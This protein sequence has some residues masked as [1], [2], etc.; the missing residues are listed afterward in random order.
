MLS[1]EAIEKFKELMKR[2]YGVDYTDKEAR[3]AAE[4]LVK[5]FE[6]LIKIDRR[7]R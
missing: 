5:F 6:L 3:Q 7:N 4:N 2:E 1:Q